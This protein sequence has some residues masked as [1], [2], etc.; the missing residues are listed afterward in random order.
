MQSRN[1]ALL[2]TCT[3]TGGAHSGEHVLLR[4]GSGSDSPILL[5]G[6]YLAAAW[7]PDSAGSP[8]VNDVAAITYTYRHV[9]DPRLSDDKRLALIEG[10]DEMRSFGTWKISRD[11]YCRLSA[12]DGAPCP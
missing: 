1:G 6:V 9:F 5:G 8:P 3:T 12:A 4:A 7:V 2:L 11:T 10:A